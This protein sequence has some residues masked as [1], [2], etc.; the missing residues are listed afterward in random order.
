MRRSLAGSAATGSFAGTLP[1]DAE[2]LP[3]VTGVLATTDSASGHLPTPTG[4]PHSNSDSGQIGTAEAGAATPHTHKPVQLVTVPDSR[5]ARP[6]GG[7]ELAA[8]PPEMPITAL[9]ELETIP[10]GG[11]TGTSRV[12]SAPTRNRAAPTLTSGSR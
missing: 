1:T 11:A 7:I 6:A 10:D 5:L 8:D 4:T 9:P 2:T 3:P 12:A